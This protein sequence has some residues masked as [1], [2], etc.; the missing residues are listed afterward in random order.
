MFEYD[1]AYG[2]TQLAERN[3]TVDLSATPLPSYLIR[4]KSGKDRMEAPQSFGRIVRYA[5]TRGPQPSAQRHPSGLFG[6]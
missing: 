6:Q 4:T 1:P 5:H 3:G 2:A